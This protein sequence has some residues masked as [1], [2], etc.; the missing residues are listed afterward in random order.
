MVIVEFTCKYSNSKEYFVGKN[1]QSVLADT[2]GGKS[3]GGE[4]FSSYRQISEEDARRLRLDFLEAGIQA[5][6][7]GHSNS[8]K[9]RVPPLLRE[10]L[11]ELVA[12]TRTQVLADIFVRHARNKENA[13]ELLENLLAKLP[14]DTS[15]TR[16][17]L[18][19]CLTILQD[20]EKESR[21]EMDRLDWRPNA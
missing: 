3:F 4:E 5:V 20:L 2:H 1:L 14:E 7:H 13:R 9:L 17:Q 6:R 15:A 16:K 10:Q 12:R 19:S 21:Q 18:E 8:Y 11:A